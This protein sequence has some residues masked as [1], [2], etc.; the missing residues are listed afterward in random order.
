MRYEITFVEVDGI[1]SFEMETN[2]IDDLNNQL[3]AKEKVSGNKFVVAEVYD[4]QEDDLL[5]GHKITNS[6]YV[7]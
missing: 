4:R 2:S 3:S 6:M 1:R 7:N 5:V